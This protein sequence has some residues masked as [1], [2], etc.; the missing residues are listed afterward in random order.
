MVHIYTG[1]TFQFESLLVPTTVRYTFYSFI[2]VNF[3]QFTIGFET[4][5]KTFSIVQFRP[6]S[7]EWIFHIFLNW[8]EECKCLDKY[9]DNF[10]KIFEINSEQCERIERLTL[11]FF[12]R[13]WMKRVDLFQK[14]LYFNANK[15]KTNYNEYNY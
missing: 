9:I 3:W 2:T 1:P 13:L 4:K 10:N 8:N 11:D 6:L 12:G 14:V 15:H 5:R 7:L